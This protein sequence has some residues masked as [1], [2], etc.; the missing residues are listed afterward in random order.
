MKQNNSFI[1]LEILILNELLR[2]K[3]IDK[4]IYDMATKKILEKNHVEDTD[5]SIL[6]ATA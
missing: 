2:N 5:L 6:K 4:N 1:P 3:H